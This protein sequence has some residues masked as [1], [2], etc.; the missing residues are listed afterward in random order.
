MGTVVSNNQSTSVVLV[1]ENEISIGMTDPNTKKGGDKDLTA[2]VSSNDSVP[3]MAPTGPK[4][5]RSEP[6]SN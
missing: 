1:D 4:K 5:T 3:V 6:D 2:P